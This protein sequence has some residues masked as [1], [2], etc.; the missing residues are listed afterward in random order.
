[1]INAGS[2]TTSIS[3]SAAFYFLLKNRSSYQRLM[4][5]LE[6]ALNSG[7]IG[8]GNG[9]LITWAESQ[10]LAYLDAVIQE[11]FRL[12]PAVGLCLERVVPKGGCII[13][14]KYIRGG[15]IV[16]CNAWVLHRQPEVFGTDANIFRPERWLD[17][18]AERLSTMKATM[19]HFGSGAR[20][21]IGKNIALLEIY[22]LLPT[23][24]LRFEV[25]VPQFLRGS[26]S[27][28]AF[29]PC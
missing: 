1:M 7:R 12:H 29:H 28:S 15:I 21:C 16:G 6:N 18:S 22:K 27:F 3:L 9:G 13:C 24:L 11:T 14:G 10:T 17:A 4:E 26:S 5:E 23:F 20:S 19:L 25:R 2:D 8:S